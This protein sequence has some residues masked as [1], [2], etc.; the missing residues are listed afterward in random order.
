MSIDFEAL[1]EP[2][3]ADEIE[4][5]AIPGY[6][7]R[8]DVSSRGDVRK[9]DR[10]VAHV[11]GRSWRRSLK[12]R[13]LKQTA[14]RGYLKVT[15]RD[16]TNRVAYVEV[17]ILVLLAFVGPRPAGCPHIRHLDGSRTNNCVGNLRYG[18][19]AENAADT[20]A[21]GRTTTGE[22]NAMS[23]LTDDDVR[24]MRAARQSGALL[25]QLADRFG[26]SVMT[27]QRAVTGQSWSHL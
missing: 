19:A 18:T 12:G 6:E 27:V 5:R 13:A 17:H 2:F 21:H 1:A 4:W 26:V 7:G 24:A 20:M 9:H 8:Y 14:S 25:R 16:A 23:R 3:P 15:L 10:V 11:A 22:R